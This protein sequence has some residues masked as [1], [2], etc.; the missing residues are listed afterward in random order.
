[1]TTDDQLNSDQPTGSAD[2]PRNDTNALGITGNLTDVFLK[3][4]TSPVEPTE[5]VAALDAAYPSNRYV[6]CMTPRSGSTYLAYLL[7]DTQAFGFPEEWLSMSFAEESA[8][9]VGARDLETYLRRVLARHASANGVSG[10]E[11]S[12]AHLIHARMEG[13]ADKLFD[14][15]FRYFYLRRRNIVRQ[16]LSMRVAL[17]SGVLHSY[18][19]SDE[20]KAARDAVP[21]DAVEIRQHIKF[22]HDEEL[23]W[24]REFGARHVEPDR[25]YYEDII[26]RPERV[27]RRFANILGLPETP[28]MPKQVEIERM[29]DS[30]AD[31]W[32]ARYRE[33]DADYLES[34]AIHRPFVHTP[35]S[36]T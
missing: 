21:F 29:S 30:K 27:L 16:G 18:Q 26:H 4:N 36:M 32:E 8:Q 35:V 7:R 12:M 5:D 23:R 17:H 28:L 20:A 1:M 13:G 19:L 22:L 34:L 15:S 11:L 25:I 3:L 9:Q 10:L 6:I 2:A 24:E 14:R 33:E 31:E